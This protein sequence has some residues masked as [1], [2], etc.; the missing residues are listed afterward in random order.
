MKDPASLSAEVELDLISRA[1]HGDRQAFGELVRCHRTGVI[2]VVFGV[3]SV[4]SEHLIASPVTRKVTFT[5]SIPVDV[6]LH[7]WDQTKGGS[8]AAD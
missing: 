3:P 8:R 1:Q 4:V 2:N 6:K 7:Y 5:G